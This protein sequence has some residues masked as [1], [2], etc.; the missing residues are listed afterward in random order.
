ME[1]K[2]PTSVEQHT[3][4]WA[5]EMALSS[6][7]DTIATSTWTADNGLIIDSDAKTNT[8]TTVV[9]SGGRLG[10]YCNLRNH[11]VTAAG[12]EYDRTMVVEIKAILID[13]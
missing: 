3:F 11:I 4:D 7:A 12:R 13:A 6:P 5:A 8:T 10:A 9:R 1:S 2:S